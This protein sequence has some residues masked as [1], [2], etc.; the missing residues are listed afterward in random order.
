[1][2]HFLRPSVGSPVSGAARADD[3]A[4]QT[5]T[6]RKGPFQLPIPLVEALDNDG[7]LRARSC[8]IGSSGV[9]VLLFHEISPLL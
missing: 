5:M 8:R 4:F 9:L 3:V 6:A 7:W 1:M 2:C